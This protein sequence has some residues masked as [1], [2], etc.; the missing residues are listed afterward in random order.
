MNNVKYFNLYKEASPIITFHLPIKKDK[1]I[2]LRDL[3]LIALGHIIICWLVK[4]NAR[5]LNILKKIVDIN[6]APDRQGLI[7]I[8]Y[9]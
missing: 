6:E 9:D 1:H 2:L 5:S 4:M 3:C 7:R 8:R